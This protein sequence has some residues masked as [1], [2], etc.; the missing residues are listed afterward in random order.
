[1]NAI[2][3]A[4][5]GTLVISTDLGLVDIDTVC[6]FFRRSYWAKDRSRDVVERSLENS[7]VFGVYDGTRQIGIARV[8]TDSATYAW[9]DD[10]FIDEAYRGQSIGKWLIATVLSHPGLQGVHRIMLATRDAHGLYRQFGF[11]PLHAPESL[12]ERLDG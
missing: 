5:R 9:L 11:T 4:H 6:D 12:M 7:L 3:E 8:V 2:L 1:M 10:V